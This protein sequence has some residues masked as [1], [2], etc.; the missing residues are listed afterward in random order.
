MIISKTPL[1]I[2]FAG[3]GTDFKDYYKLNFGAVVSTTINKYIYVNVNKKF[4]DKIRVSY[5]KT[6]MVEEIDDLQHDLVKET[7]RLLGI[8]KGIE[9]TTVA[10]IPSK[11]SGLGSSSC[12]L[13]GLL[14]V[15]HRYKGD[16]VNNEQLAQEAY[17][18]EVDILKRPIGK[19]DHYASA[20]GGLNLIK[21]NPDETVRVEP[22]KG[23]EYLQENFMMFYTGLTRNAAGI[24]THQIREINNKKEILD[25]M[26]DLAIKLKDF[27]DFANILHE[28]WQYKKLLAPN[29]TNGFIDQYYK[30]AQDAG[31]LGGK[32]CGAGGGGFFLFYCEKEKQDN[33]RRALSDLKE[34]QFRFE[35]EGSKIIYEG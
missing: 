12:L 33:V 20:Y 5:T 30:K 21:F 2:S 19:Q 1:R 4:D 32:L 18:I 22:I 23:K 11:G 28:G 17:R 9:I 24:L 35:P 31:V 25:K 26:R 10:D 7:L 29:I 8:H 13:V 3:G 6:E 34:M 14:N 27:N 16:E 15:L